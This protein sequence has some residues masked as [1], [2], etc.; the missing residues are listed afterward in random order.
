MYRFEPNGLVRRFP[1]IRR[2]PVRGAFP[3]QE[4]DMS[5]VM[6]DVVAF[7]KHIDIVGKPGSTVGCDFSEWAFRQMW[8]AR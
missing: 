7:R 3:L 2:F 6:A 8:T 5:D 4:N 1:A